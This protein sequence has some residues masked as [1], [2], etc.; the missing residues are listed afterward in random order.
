[1][2]FVLHVLKLKSYKLFHHAKWSCC[3]VV[4]QGTNDMRCCDVLLH[5]VMN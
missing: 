2:F 5:V 4:C 1:M 3:V